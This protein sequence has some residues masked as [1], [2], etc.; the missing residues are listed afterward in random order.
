MA[1]N[2]RLLSLFLVASL[3]AAAPGFVQHALTRR[4]VNASL[5]SGRHAHAPSRLP[6]RALQSGEVPVF[7][8]FRRLAYFYADLYI[9][10]AAPAPQRFSVI[11]DTGSSL[12][13]VPC[14]TCALTML[15][16]AAASQCTPIRNLDFSKS[17]CGIFFVNASAR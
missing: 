14:A 7:G 11:A 10:S 1:Q 4:V 13:A 3:A 16:Y 17:T 5:A 12:T 8:D 9:G 15:K 2:A 6:A